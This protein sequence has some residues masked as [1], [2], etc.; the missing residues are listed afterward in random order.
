[1]QPFESTAI[2]RTN[3]APAR[4]TRPYGKLLA[5]YEFA[6]TYST[7]QS[8]LE[9]WIL[10]LEQD[11]LWI[12]FLIEGYANRCVKNSSLPHAEP[13]GWSAL[14]DVLQE[15]SA[16]L[17]LLCRNGNG[18]IV[19]ARKDLQYLSFWSDSQPWLIIGVSNSVTSDRLIAAIDFCHRTDAAV[20]AAYV[21]LNRA[22]SSLRWNRR[23][24]PCER[25]TTVVLTAMGTPWDL[26]T[27]LDAIREHWKEYLMEASE[28]AV[29]FGSLFFYVHSPVMRA[30][31]SVFARKAFMGVAMGITTILLVRSPFGKRS[32]GH[33]NPALTLT[34]F[35]L[36]KVRGWDTAFYI[37]GQFGGGL[38]GVLIEAW[39][40]GRILSHPSVNYVVT[41]PGA[42]KMTVAFAAETFMAF[43]LM[44]II[45]K[46]SN[47][48]QLAPYTSSIVGTLMACYIIL[49]TSVSGF[50]VNPARTFSSGAV[51]GIWTGLWIYFMAPLLGMIT[52][53]GTYCH[54]YGV[55]QIYCAKID[56]DTDQ[57]CPFLCRVA[58][59]KS[60]RFLDRGC[61]SSAL[62]RCRIE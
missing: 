55:H 48:P 8:V 52:A 33:L 26:S 3:T 16:M 24:N 10:S 60:T 11:L 59:L 2:T 44:I 5:D 49:F 51:A 21:S 54:K 61:I 36:G 6:P 18:R 37:I 43:V 53:A 19:I 4:L 41:V 40:L 29:G 13:P 39:M 34:Y 14:E 47:S 35:W 57:P 31:P 32:G 38:M 62:P 30:A 25:H 50:S 7:L 46:S 22:Q 17:P 20:G 23:R 1:M 56:H 45:L 42:H 27:P 58:E 9:S 15:A 12:G 28:L